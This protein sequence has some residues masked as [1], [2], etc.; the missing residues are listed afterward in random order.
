MN[1][2]VLELEPPGVVT[3]TAFAPMLVLAGVT[4]VMDVTLT[5]VKL[6]T[7][8]E[9]IFTL[10]APVKLVPKI[11]IAVPPACGPELGVT[12]VI[13]GKATLYKNVTASLVDPPGV[14][15]TTGFAPTVAL[16]G[17]SPVILSAVT[18]TM[19]VTALPSIVTLEAPVKLLPKMEMA[20]PPAI[21]P[22]DGA[23]DAITGAGVT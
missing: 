3:V 12:E 11:V 2:F 8:I 13:V 21:V 9:L 7:S 1:A 17:V 18:T 20:V 23:T 6:V 22:F 14:V 5:T 15:T 10:V 16:D 19:L 4:A